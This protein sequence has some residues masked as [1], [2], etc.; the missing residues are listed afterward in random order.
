MSKRALIVIDVQND[1]FPGGKWELHN[2]EASAA[3]A[4]RVL[5]N[6]R[7]NGETVIHVRHESVE[8]NAPFFAP[9]SFGAEFHST[10]KPQAGELEVLKHHVNSFKE[11]NLKQLLDER[12][13]TDVTIV[14]D[15]SH[16]CIDAATRAAADY[17]YVVTVVEDACSSRDLEFNGEIIPAANTHKAYMSALGFAY[18]T[19]T[20][21]SEYVAANG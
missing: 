10:A 8:D 1:Y 21:T 11:T 14:G 16:M 18:A 6:A 20:T 4:V 5:E 15:M 12:G 19:I 17:G 7:A 13:I 3:N 2:I 9:G